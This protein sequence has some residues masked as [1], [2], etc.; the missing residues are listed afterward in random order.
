LIA[1]AVLEL[2]ND[3]L[4]GLN[5]EEKSRLLILLHKTTDAGNTKSCAPFKKAHR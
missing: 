3:I 2:Q 4:C 5:D 1:P